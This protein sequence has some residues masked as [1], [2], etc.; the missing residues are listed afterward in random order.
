MMIEMIEPMGSDQLA[1]SRLG[2]APVSLR[3]PAESPVKAG[4]RIAVAI[5]SAKVNLFDR[6]SG[7]RL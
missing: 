2:G 4:D 1:W 7:R 3:L 6:A 5:A